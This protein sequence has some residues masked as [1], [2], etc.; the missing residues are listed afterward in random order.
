MA[1]GLISLPIPGVAHPLAA[2]QSG[3]YL[4]VG[5]TNRQHVSTNPYLR[6]S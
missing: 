3:I 2:P 5:K 6:C 4:G 1:C